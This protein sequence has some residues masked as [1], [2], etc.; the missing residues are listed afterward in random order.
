MVPVCLHRVQSQVDMR[1]PFNSYNSCIE[2]KEE[3]MIANIELKPLNSSYLQFVKS[4][5]SDSEKDIESQMKYIVDQFVK[6][7]CESA[8]F[9]P[10]NIKIILRMFKEQLKG[11]PQAKVDKFLW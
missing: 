11:C 4:F 6:D 5:N 1:S 7:I 2:V 8:E 3:D 9:F 10:I